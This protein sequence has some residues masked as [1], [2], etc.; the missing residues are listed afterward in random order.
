MSETKATP[1]PG[2]KITAGKGFHITFAN[3]W[4]VSVQFGFGN[5]CDGRDLHRIPDDI[6]AYDQEA[7]AKGDTTAEVA[8]WS[9]DGELQRLEGWNDTVAGWQ[10]PADVIALFNHVAAIAKAEGE[11]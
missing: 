10:S 1:R 11:S 3:G 7:G 8:F 6:S 9:P 4:T 5:Y 2:F